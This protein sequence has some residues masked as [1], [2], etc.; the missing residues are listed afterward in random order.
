MFKEGNT[1]CVIVGKMCFVLHRIVLF[2]LNLLLL[3]KYILNG[4][5]LFRHGP[6]T[7]ADT[8]PNDPYINETFEPYGWG[9]ITNVSDTIFEQFFEQFFFQCFLFQCKDASY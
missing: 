9:H 8:Y 6:R 1:I 4:L 7:P 5:Q 3:L 2:L